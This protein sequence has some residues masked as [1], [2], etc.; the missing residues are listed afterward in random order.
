VQCCHR[1]RRKFNYLFD[2]GNDHQALV[3]IFRRVHDALIPG[4]VFVFDIAEPGQVIRR[5][6]NKG[7]SEGEDWLVLVE[8]EEDLER[9]MLTRRITSFRKVGDLYN[10]V[11]K[12]HRLRL[13][14][15]TEIAVELS[16]IGF[17]V[18]TMHSYGR[19]QLPR[20]HAALV[21]RKLARAD[22]SS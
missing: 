19:Y 4:G 11:D 1:Y 21:A 3:R 8:K 16:Q 15:S 2:P 17:R 12:V 14:K 18:Q 7:F 22:T 13:F 20:A 6:T 10:R 9:G 5:D